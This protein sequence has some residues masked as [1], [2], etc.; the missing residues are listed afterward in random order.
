ML[1]LKE[2]KALLSTFKAAASS[3]KDEDAQLR[4]KYAISD[5]AARTG[6]LA[7]I[8]RMIETGAS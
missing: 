3:A 6:I 5:Q 8:H 2:P 1:L 7:V 4:R